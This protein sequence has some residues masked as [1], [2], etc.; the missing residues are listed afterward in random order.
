MD[1]TEDTRTVGIEFAGQVYKFAPL[2]EGQQ[3]ALLLSAK[4]GRMA[5]GSFAR[6]LEK[7]C[8]AE[9]W[10]LIMN[11]IMD[12]EITMNDLGDALTKLAQASGGE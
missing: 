7:S 12:D 5:L 1:D 4:S 9:T 3:T 2:T 6:V 10:E 8:G 11:R